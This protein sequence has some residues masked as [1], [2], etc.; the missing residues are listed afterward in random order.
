[1]PVT[2]LVTKAEMRQHVWGG[3]HVSDTVVRVCVQ[4][5]R[6]ALGDAVAAP[7]YLETVGRQGYRWLG[8]DDW[9]QP[10]LVAPGAPSPFIGRQAEV[11]VLGR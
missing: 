3:T 6:V 5:I 4:E 1:M 11:E 10:A 8:G 2:R 7:R 9:E